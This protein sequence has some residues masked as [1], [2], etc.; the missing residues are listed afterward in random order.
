MKIDIEVATL[1]S[2]LESLESMGVVLDDDGFQDLHTMYGRE[3]SQMI[4]YAQT[5][6]EPRISLSMPHQGGRQIV[7][8]FAVSDMQ[9]LEKPELNWHL[10]NT[11]QWVYAGAL[12]YDT[13]D[14]E[15]SSHH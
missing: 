14:K 3:L 4:Q 7:I 9:K 10:Q 12:V 15:W 11:S 2:I 6:Q 13:K 8:N 1:N 5:A